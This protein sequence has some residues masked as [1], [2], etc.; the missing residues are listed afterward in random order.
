MQELYHYRDRTCRSYSLRLISAALAIAGGLCV[1]ALVC[2]MAERTAVRLSPTE[3]ARI[4]FRYPTLGEMPNRENTAKFL[5]SAAFFG[6]DTL[7]FDEGE[8]NTG[9]HDPTLSPS[10]GEDM[11]T[12]HN[13]LAEPQTPPVPTGDLYAY[14]ASACPAGEYALRPYDLTGNASAGE[15][16][17]SNATTLTVNVPDALQADYPIADPLTSDPLVLILHTHGTEAFAPENAVSVPKT[18]VMRSSDPNENIVAVGKLMADILNEAGIPTLHC[19]IMHDLES[20][21]RSYDLAA[22]TIQKYLTEYPSIRYVFDVHRDAILLAN[23]DY[24]RP[25]TLV[26]GERSAQIMLLVGTDEKGADH[27]RWQDNFTVA[28]KLQKKLTEQYDRF[29]RPINIRGASFNEQFTKGSLLIEIGSAG[30]TLS[31]A[32]AAAK[33]LTYAIAE[34]IRENQS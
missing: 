32:K 14:D 26:D 23:G 18:A 7:Y 10:E 34:L 17:I 5:L 4:C 16:L 24:V 33:H 12:P 11:Q 8:E 29:A 13:P 30:N 3:T 15:V 27:P 9:T 2:R 28:A 22:D 25:L 6:S 31:E 20:Y 21:R 1:T 19:E